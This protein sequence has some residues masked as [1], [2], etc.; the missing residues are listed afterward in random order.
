ME[1]PAVERKGEQHDIPGDGSRNR[2]ADEQ[3]LV[4]APLHV[5]GLHAV[6]RGWRVADGVE[7]AGDGTQ[8][9]LLR[10]PDDGGQRPADIETA[11]GDTRDHEGDLLH[12]PDAGRA[13]DLEI[14]LDGGHSIFFA[15]RQ[16]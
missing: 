1:I 7:E 9:S 3:C 11:L 15:G 8:R 4:L 14:E 5:A 2:D 16:Q 13:V 6:E 10:I 12:Q